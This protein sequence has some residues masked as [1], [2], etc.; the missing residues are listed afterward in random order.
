M[1][2]PADLSA[3]IAVFDDSDRKCTEHVM[4]EVSFSADIKPLFRSI[5]ISHMKPFGVELD[6]YTYM[7]E[8][9]NASRFF[10]APAPPEIYTLTLPAALPI[11][12]SAHKLLFST[13]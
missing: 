9:G 1:P 13:S 3:Q 10:T 8:T 7:S 6:D 5:D 4:P 2:G 12:T 11:S